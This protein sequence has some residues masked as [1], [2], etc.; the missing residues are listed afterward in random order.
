[1]TN[2]K[3]MGF[4]EHLE[5]LR[6]HAIRA[7]SSVFVFS[8]MAFIYKDFF[9]DKLVLGPS[10]FAVSAT[11]ARALLAHWGKWLGKGHLGLGVQG[12]SAG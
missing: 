8:I 7:I 6:W 10:F 3:D 2:E 5:E 1:M 12:C 9:F 11:G 4:L